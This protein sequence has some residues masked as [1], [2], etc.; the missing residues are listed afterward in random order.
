MNETYDQTLQADLSTGS[1]LGR[2]PHQTALLLL[3]VGVRIATMF[4]VLKYLSHSFGVEGFG[5]LSQ[6][7]GIGALFSTFAGGG[8]INGIVRE[9]ASASSIEDKGNWTRA[10]IVVSLY[11]SVFLA[12]VSI[13]LYT[14]FSESIFPESNL[15]WVFLFIGVVQFVTSIGNT[16]SALLLA[17]GSIKEYTVGGILGAVL[18][19]FAILAANHYFGFSGAVAGASIFAAGPAIGTL[20]IYI[21]RNRPTIA[22]VASI[23]TEGAKVARLLSYS[24]NMIF[25]A[26]VVPLVIVFMRSEL[27]RV[28]GW[29]SVGE[30]QAVARIGEAYMQFFGLLLTSVLLPRLSVVPVSERW[31]ITRNFAAVALSIFAIGAAT[32]LAF[33][34]SI[35]K[36]VYS[37]EFVTAAAFIGPQLLADFLKI[38]AAMFVFQSLADGRPVVQTIGEVLQACVMAA[39][40][41]FVLPNEAMSAVWSYVFGTA[42]ALA[43]L[44]LLQFG[45]RLG[46]HRN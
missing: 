4:L 6:V 16:T 39:V 21:L 32:F 45:S 12:A 17:Q 5:I 28:H 46:N 22:A 26:F 29:A 30:W 37:G 1:Q 24:Y 18:S 20:A 33:G 35:L 36:V 27:G 34:S 44:I 40:F 31:T 38:I 14:F 13:V 10:S 23:K 7:M 43:Y 25:A 2:M 8:N 19:T 11:S 15:S 41:I 3:V 9:V 42:A